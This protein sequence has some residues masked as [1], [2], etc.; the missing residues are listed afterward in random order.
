MPSGLQKGLV[1]LVFPMLDTKGAGG[2]PASQ[3]MGTQADG[4]K[5]RKLGPRFLF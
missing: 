2:F 4:K 1:S 3:Q 5:K